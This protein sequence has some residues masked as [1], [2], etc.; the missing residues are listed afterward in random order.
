MEYILKDGRKI[1]IRKAFDFDALE[2]IELIK[3]GDKE[4]K[5]LI[6]EPNEIDIS[7]NEAIKFIQS[8]SNDPKALLFVATLDSKVIGVAN[9]EP[10]GPFKRIEHRGKLSILVLNDYSNLG[11]GTSF[12]DYAIKKAKLMNYE[13]LELE[14]VSSNYY[15]IKLYKR[16]GFKEIGVRKNAMKYQDN[17]YADI[18]LMNLNLNEI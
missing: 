1:N 16:F 10:A 2:I 9:I 13:F 15:A 6:C 17:T 7:V 8:I 12:V 18:I 3:I 14:V 4:T 5:F 11:I